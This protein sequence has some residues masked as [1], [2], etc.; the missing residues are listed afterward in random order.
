MCLDFKASLEKKDSK[1]SRELRG[2]RE[3]QVWMD[4]REKLVFLGKTA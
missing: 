2:P 1:E 3:K 4:L